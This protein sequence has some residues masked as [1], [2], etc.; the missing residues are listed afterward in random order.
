[1]REEMGHWEKGYRNEGHGQRSEEATGEG[2]E[3]EKRRSTAYLP[4]EPRETMGELDR[5]IARRGERSESH[6]R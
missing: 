4:Q 5:T 2:L 1:M 6:I 3:S